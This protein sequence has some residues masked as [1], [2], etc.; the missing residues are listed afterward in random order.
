M[1]PFKFEDIED[2]DK[3][4]TS[5]I[6]AFAD[7]NYLVTRLIN[8]FSQEKT[9]VIDVGCSTGR[10]LRSLPKREKVNYLGIDK[11]MTPLPAEGVFFKKAD[12]FDFQALSSGSLNKYLDTS[13]VI[14]L[15]TMQFLP[16]KQRKSFIEKVDQLLVDGGIF[17]CAEK[18][19]MND[20][21]IESIVQA[22]LL[23]WKKQHFNDSEILDKTISL[24]S[25]MFCQTENKF[26]LEMKKIGAVENIWQW[27]QFVCKVARKGNIE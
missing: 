10:L 2:F 8:D 26:D 23:E 19:H 20:R 25:I 6:P 11:T 9:W 4:I 13:V 14:S 16:L 15:F 27:G 3:H 1:K 17:I 22:N 18:V 12:V 24:K 21:Y 7:L 5:S